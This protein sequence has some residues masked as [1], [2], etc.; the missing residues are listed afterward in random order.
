MR[1]GLAYDL[2]SEF[3]SEGTIEA[4]EG[5]IRSLG[6]ATDRIGSIRALAARLANGEHWDL[7][8][9]I[10]EGLTGRSREAQVPA[11]LEAFGL[12]YTFSD[13]LV[14]AATLDKAVAKR[15]VRVEGVP[16]APFAL[17]RRVAEADAVDL[18]FPLFAKP[19][20]RGPARASRRAPRSA[21][22]PSCA[23][24]APS[25]SP[26]TPS[27]CWSRPISPAAS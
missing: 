17:V 1:V 10:T 20:R 21:A 19:V 11:L 14:M 22:G 2:R 3:D 13:P 15:L 24:S 8:F 27:R 25:L 5:A 16:R 7:V 23:R 4:L 26:A 9:N 6:Y 18:P 12:P